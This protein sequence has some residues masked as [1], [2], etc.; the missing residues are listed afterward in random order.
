MGRRGQALRPCSLPYMVLRDYGDG[1]FAH[2]SLTL[3][4]GLEIYW[5][6]PYVKLWTFVVL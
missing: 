5:T 3:A 1:C 6:V 4:L 2:K